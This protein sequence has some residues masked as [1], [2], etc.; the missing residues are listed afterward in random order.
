VDIVVDPAE[1]ELDAYSAAELSMQ[2]SGARRMDLLAEFAQR[3]PTPGNR[4]I[5]LRFRRSPVEILADPDNQRVAGMRLVR[6][7]LTPAPDGRLVARPTGQMEDL[8]CGL[9]V[10]AIGYRA[11]PIPGIALDERTGVIRNVEGRVVDATGDPLPGEY[12]VGWAK[13]GPSGVIGTNKSDAEKTVT[14]IL[15]DIE[16]GWRQGARAPTAKP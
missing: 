4:Q 7:A 3:R 11:H 9:V 6:N 12:V 14:L 2:S 10:R 13:R 16:S 15:A 1:L 8:A 5:E